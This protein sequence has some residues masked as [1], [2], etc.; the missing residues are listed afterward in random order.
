[1]PHAFAVERRLFQC[2]VAVLALVPVSAGFAGV[3]LG[4]GFLGLEGAP[5]DD[6][7]SHLRFLS[8][9]FMAA[10]VGFWSCIPGIEHRTERFRLLSACTFV[11]GL[12]R[13]FSV[14]EV[15]MPSAGHLF[16]LVMELAVVP[17]LVVWQARIARRCG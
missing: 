3:V 16:G 10:G 7:D 11:G 5:P 6:L 14:I 17:A 1:M 4:P 12:A 13:L 2:V 8:G 15:G 9:F